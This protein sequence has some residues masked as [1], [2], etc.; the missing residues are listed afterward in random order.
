M[1]D[2]AVPVVGAPLAGAA[3]AAAAAPIPP[4]LPA[5]AAVAA[6]IGNLCDP[7][8]QRVADLE[9][10]RRALVYERKQVQK[11]LK[12]EQRKRRRILEKAK[13]LSDS[14]LCQVMAARA[15]AKAVAQAKAVAKAKAKAGPAA[16]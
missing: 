11:E 1:A 14:E 4:P 13:T 2:A 12:N 9:A 15:K 6:M 10:Q 7:G 16:G 5:A 8:A 3:A